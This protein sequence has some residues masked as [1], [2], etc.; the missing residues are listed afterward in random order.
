MRRVHALVVVLALLASPMSLLAR[1]WNCG[2][3]CCEMICCAKHH[4]ATASPAAR[5]QA[6][7]A[8]A[9][10]DAAGLPATCDG[11]CKLRRNRH[12]LDY[13]FSVLMFPGFPLGEGYLAE[14][15]ALRFA[16]PKSESLALN[17][18]AFPPFQPPR[19]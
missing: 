8:I 2:D 7:A 16:I 13:G 6:G 3:C 5:G 14:T 4:G 17:G 19:S 9:N 15:P 11:H 10:S 12:L 18:F 1:A